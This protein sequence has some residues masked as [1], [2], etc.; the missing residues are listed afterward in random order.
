MVGVGVVT[1][2]EWCQEPLPEHVIQRFDGRFAVLCG[3]CERR[4]ELFL[5]V[6]GD[7]VEL[8]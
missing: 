1:D 8:S 3:E 6:Y 2:C 7:Q 4:L 5:N